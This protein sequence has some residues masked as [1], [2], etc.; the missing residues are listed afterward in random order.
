MRATTLTFFLILCID[1]SSLSAQQEA[2]L[3]GGVVLPDGEI[4]SGELLRQER[5]RMQESVSFRDLEDK[6]THYSPG[7][8]RGA[9]FGTVCSP[10]SGPASFRTRLEGEWFF[11]LPV[12]GI[13][14]RFCLMRLQGLFSLFSF[15]QEYPANPFPAQSNTVR[16][17][18]WFLAGPADTMALTDKNFRQAL[19]NEAENCPELDKNRLMNTRFTLVALTKLLIQL[20]ECRGDTSRYWR[21][22]PF[23]FALDAGGFLRAGGQ[24]GRLAKTD[25]LKG[26][27]LARQSERGPYPSFYWAAGGQIT[28]QYTY[29]LQGRLSYMYEQF[30]G[31]RSFDADGFV[32]DELAF[33][34]NSRFVSL[35]QLYIFRPQAH[36][37]AYVLLG[38]SAFTRS[39]IHTREWRDGELRAELDHEISKSSVG[40]HT[41]GGWKWQ[42][43]RGVFF[44]AEFQTAFSALLAGSTPEIGMTM[45]RLYGQAGISA[46]LVR[47]KPRCTVPPVN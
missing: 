29:H 27:Y 43:S 22:P 16:K 42:L 3:E 5:V 19:L 26:G 9:F 33:R 44:H 39:A 45:F 36:S 28:F 37:S 20:N 18:I 13:G 40:I 47:R 34:A 2:W 46:Q 15:W 35:D 14:R 24:M 32:F 6:V 21:E 7:E 30:S 41:G 17:E 1:I 4:R 12:P 23:I 25:F 8:L 10:A 31:Y 38:G 11:S